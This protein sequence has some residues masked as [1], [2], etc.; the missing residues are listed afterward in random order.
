MKIGILTFHRAH[1]YGAVLQAY[2]LQEFLINLGYNVEIIDYRPSYLIEPYKPLSISRIINGSIKSILK[3]IVLSI[4]LLP[5]RSKRWLVFNKFIKT[6]FKLSKHIRPL[7]YDKYDLY[8]IGSDQIW[9]K[10]ITKGFDKV[11]WGFFG[12]HDITNKIT[13]AASFGDYENLSEDREFIKQALLNFSGISLREKEHIEFINS[14]N[15]KQIYKVLDPT[16]ILD[17]AKWKEKAVKPRIKNK[18]VLIYQVS[19]SYD[20]NR[21]ASEIAQ[22]LDVEVVEISADITTIKFNKIK[23]T[24]S[25]FE[26]VGWIKYAECIVT[27]SFHGT[28]FSIIFEKDFYMINLANGS[29]KRSHDILLELGLEDRMIPKKSSINFERICYEKTNYLLDKLKQSSLEY[30]RSNLEIDI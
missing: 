1:N 30:L 25:P 23:Y 7:S 22:Q 28:A 3:K 4:I 17:V 6:Y 29:E 9:N 19:T 24:V 26:F 21:I 8:I 10:R 11:F 27:T 20:T 18:Y 14:L 15:E 16:F 13:Y 5:I 12:K 2:A